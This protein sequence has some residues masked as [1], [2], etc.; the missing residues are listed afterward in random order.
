VVWVPEGSFVRPV[1]VQL[2]L[3]DGLKTEVLGDALREGQPVVVGEKLP[4][5]GGDAASPFTPRPFGR[6]R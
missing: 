4:A 6:G 3:S 1:E 5:E 2:G